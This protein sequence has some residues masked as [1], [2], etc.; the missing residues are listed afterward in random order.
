MGSTSSQT[1]S[2][3][4]PLLSL[5]SP[6]HVLPHSASAP[7]FGSLCPKRAW[8]MHRKHTP[9]LVITHLVGGNDRVSQGARLPE[10]R[11]RCVDWRCHRCPRPSGSS[12]GANVPSLVRKV[13]S[14]CAA[15]DK[16]CSL[17]KK[18]QQQ[19]QQKKTQHVEDRLAIKR[20]GDN[21]QQSL[22][23]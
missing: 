5:S 16:H 17:K 19:Q 1:C 14:W 22:T 12:V 18:T 9:R 11:M 13:S 8:P 20:D 3:F 7:R 6:I 4:S 10:E 2:L 15:A 23:A 21:E